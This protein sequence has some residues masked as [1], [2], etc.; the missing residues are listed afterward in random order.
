[1]PLSYHEAPPRDLCPSQLIGNPRIV[2][3]GFQQWPYFKTALA[4]SRFLFLPNIHDAS[5]RVVSEALASDTPV[6]M[7]GHVCPPFPLP[8]TAHHYPLWAQCVHG[9]SSL[10]CCRPGPALATLAM[11][12]TVAPKDAPSTHLAW[13]AICCL[14]PPLPQCG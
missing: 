11:M 3:L 7:N 2:V 13:G 8:L 4:V 10:V 12:C 9:V 5:P 1:M 6:L 14:P